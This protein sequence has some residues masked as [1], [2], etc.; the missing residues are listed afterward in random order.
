MV[1]FILITADVNN[2]GISV[3][4]T[5]SVNPITFGGS[6]RGESLTLTVSATSITAGGRACDES[7]TPTFSVTLITGE[8]ESDSVVDG[9]SSQLTRLSRAVTTTAISSIINPV[10]MPGPSYPFS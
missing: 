4:R 5:A 6:A 1:S 7:V 3:T 10:F 9:V 2:R 8:E